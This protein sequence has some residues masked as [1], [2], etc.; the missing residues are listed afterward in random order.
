M[1]LVRHKVISSLLHADATKGLHVVELSQDE[2]ERLTEELHVT[3]RF[4]PETPLPGYE[5]RDMLLVPFNGMKIP[6]VWK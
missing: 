3:E 2:F 4:I 1:E 5:D 6:V